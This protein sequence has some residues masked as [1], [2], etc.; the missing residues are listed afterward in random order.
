VKR[1]S[2]Y[3]LGIIIAVLILATLS[4]KLYGADFVAE[5]VYGSVWFLI[6]W[7]VF[8]LSALICLLK[9]RILKKTV[10]MMLHFSFLLIL[11]GAFVTRLFG[12][13]G[14]LRVREGEETACFT[15]NFTNNS[16][17]TGRMPFA[18]K[19]DAFR[20]VYYQG[21]R[22]PMDFV[23]TVTITDIETNNVIDDEI[24]MNK[25][26]L[27]RGYRFYQSGYDDDEKGVTLTVSHD[28]YGVAVTY[29]GYLF[30]LVSVGS[31]FL[32]RHSRFRRLLNR[33]NNPNKPL[34][35]RDLLVLILFF[36]TNNLH[37]AAQSAGSAAGKQTLTT[38]EPTVLPPA[39]AAKFGDLYIFYND[40]VCPLQTLAKDF[41]VKL[42]GR[43][44]YKGLTAEQ[45]FT[46]WMFYYSSWKKQP[47]IKVKSKAVRQMLGLKG[48]YAS[49]DDFYGSYNEYKLEKAIANIRRG[50]TTEGRRA[51]EDADEKYNLIAVLYSGKM[52]KI[53]PHASRN[54][55]P[56]ESGAGVR[57]D[58]DD[59]ARRES[60]GIDVESVEAGRDSVG[61]EY[62]I[63]YSQGDLLPEDMD[64]GEWLFVTKSFDYIQEMV[65]RK[66]FEA[67]SGM[68]AKMKVY[69]QK[70]AGR[71]LPPDSR[72]EAEKIY[73]RLDYTK[74]VAMLCLFLGIASFLLYCNSLIN[75]R[76]ASAWTEAVLCVFGILVFLFVTVVI[77]LRWY[78]SAHVPLSNGFETMQFMAWCTIILSFLMRGKFFMSL[79]FGFLLCGLTLL[80][81]ML[82]ESNPRITQPMPVLLSPLLSLHVVVIM[83]SYSLFAFMMLNGLTAVVLSFVRKENTMQI[84]RL[85]VVSRVILYPAV[86]CLAIGIFVG[87]VWANISWGRY[88]GWDPKEVW[89][90][91]T[92][93]LY[94]L[95]LHPDSLLLF[96]RPMF[97]HVF[98]IVAFLSI[99]IT[100]FGVNLF[101]GGMHSYA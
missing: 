28:P 80:V 101:F 67:L 55:L 70:K 34:S 36:C 79:P 73:N 15:D 75:S 95:A 83:V 94:S 10:V 76:K 54:V 37:V 92:M 24:A 22:V 32:N 5:H 20:I 14:T 25:I 82:G 11:T 29:S 93:L 8:S 27:Y 38:I 71:F 30:F 62:I 51:V 47:M 96:R 39:V 88:W 63:W 2:F 99:L 18:V 17:M 89:A 66:D 57:L 42:Y 64:D 59:G 40:R 21:T 4:E 16:G 81:A 56:R 60:V 68:L 90:L 78:V 65:V 26:L 45:I 31:F 49:L 19:L 48:G 98:S 69:Q 87:A 97:F 58:N 44:S 9:R 91:A 53:F 3:L 86:F 85:Y 84:E 43:S 7:S 74:S 13:R 41:T 35:A 1:I 46:G 61:E 100:Y 72:F 23:S 12:E 52:I 6:L 50:V 33:F 77:C